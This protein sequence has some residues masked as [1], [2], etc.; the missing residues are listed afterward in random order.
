[1]LA[2]CGEG[3]FDVLGLVQNKEKWKAENDV[4][5]AQKQMKLDMDMG[6]DR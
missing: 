4:G 5:V 3:Q 2:K 1:M 6:K